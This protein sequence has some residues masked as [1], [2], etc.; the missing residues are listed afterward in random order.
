MGFQVFR[1][2]FA[3]VLW[4]YVSLQSA[5]LIR[6]GLMYSK[7]NWIFLGFSIFSCLAAASFFFLK[8][9]DQKRKTDIQIFLVFSAIAS[10][11]LSI[12]PWSEVDRLFFQELE[13][14][15]SNSFES[16]ISDK[17]DRCDYV[18]TNYLNLKPDMLLL[19]EKVCSDKIL[20]IS[21]RSNRELHQA[22]N[23]AY[24]E[25][26]KKPATFQVRALVCLYAET[27]QKEFA[28][29]IADKHQMT[30]LK[31]VL[32]KRSRCLGFSGREIASSKE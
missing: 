27:N 19:L 15:E 26:A 28:L 11:V 17:I 18:K 22:F 4:G 30:D 31:E 23:W 7:I 16:T 9:S 13:R 32:V 25:Y 1:F 8:L 20:Q 5:E 24:V 29:Q 6:S 10:N 21:Q 12:R 3:L 2:I 14:I